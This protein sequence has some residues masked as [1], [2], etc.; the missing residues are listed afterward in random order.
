LFDAVV[1]V[2]GVRPGQEDFV[3]RH[4]NGSGDVVD[5]GDNDPD[6]ISVPRLIEPPVSYFRQAAEVLGASLVVE[7]K[8]GL[9]DIGH[10]IAPME[11]ERV[12][13][14]AHDMEQYALQGWGTKISHEMPGIVTFA[15]ERLDDATQRRDG[16]RVKIDELRGR[17]DE[18]EDQLAEPQL[19]YFRDSAG[20]RGLAF[21]GTSVLAVIET[22]AL[23]GMVEQALHLSD[24]MA[25]GVAFG[26]VVLLNTASFYA[27][28]GLHRAHLHEGPARSRRV[29]ALPAIF[30]GMA[31]LLGLVGVAAIRFAT[32]HAGAELGWT[33]YAGLQAAGQGLAALAGWNAGNSRSLELQGAREELALAEQEER[34][35]AEYTASY[36]AH[37]ELEDFDVE[38][39]LG[40]QAPYVA[41]RYARQLTES[42]A[43]RHTLLAANPGALTVLRTLPWPDFVP[44]VGAIDPP[45]DADWLT[46]FTLTL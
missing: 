31:A 14:G 17:L 16:H 37:A 44:L 33:F 27:M 45:D 25:W 23:K 39:Y 38:E 19:R 8:A 20:A 15:R 35:D 12:F 18:L 7:S 26:A 29:M 11:S 40:L 32:D 9:P 13:V 4:S 3:A 22:V 41:K 42:R 1:R 43:Q 30:V 24:E 2:A 34:F 36:E 10:P 6:H 28:R 21:L 46:G 5:S